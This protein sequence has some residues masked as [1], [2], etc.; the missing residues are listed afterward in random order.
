MSR[1]ATLTT[2][3]LLAACLATAPTAS[4]QD[5]SVS[6]DAWQH[7]SDQT[8]DTGPETL[9]GSGGSPTLGGYGGVGVKY[10][11][12]DQ[13]NVALVCGEGALLLDHQFS[14][15][16][17]GCGMPNRLD[18]SAYSGVA[19][20]EMEVGYGGLLLRYH[21]RSHDMVSFSLGGVVGG[22]GLTIGQWNHSDTMDEGVVRE[23]DAFFAAEPQA[24][25][26]V[27]VTRWL[28]VGAV[29]GYRFV[30]G[31]NTAGLS[32]TDLAGPTGGAHILF[33]WF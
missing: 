11:R 31:T 7:A 3:A 13:S 17:A 18:G 27:N 15:G 23:S 26:D 8:R 30:S 20:D 25:V 6:P 10:S 24:T 22:G 28:R 19:N 32:N 14:L 9:F 21:F 1:T 4:A 12:V 5:A 2:V 29:G 16:L 33:G